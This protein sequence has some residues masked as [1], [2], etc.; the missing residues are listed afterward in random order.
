MAVFR[1]A[2]RW[3]AHLTEILD[4][5]DVDVFVAGQIEQRIKQHRAVAG[6]KNEPVTIGPIRVLRIEREIAGK[7]NRR[8]IGCAHGQSG[9]TGIG[10]LDRIDRK[11]ADRIGHAVVLVA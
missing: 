3:R 10:F 1:V 7:Q 5:G 9:V 11:K 6:R 2:G 8:D 4:I